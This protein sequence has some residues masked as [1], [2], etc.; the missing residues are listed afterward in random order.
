MSVVST[1]TTADAGCSDCQKRSGKNKSYTRKRLQFTHPNVI[2]G[3][4]VR[5]VTN[6][7]ADVSGTCLATVNISI[8][9]APSGCPGLT[10]PKHIPGHAD[11]TGL[12]FE[13]LA[14]QMPS[15]I[16]RF[17][18]LR[19]TAPEQAT[20]LFSPHSPPTPLNQAPMHLKAP[21]L[22]GKKLG[23]CQLGF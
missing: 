14:T 12:L 17:C 23:L 7:I 3:R 11:H 8:C 21:A 4:C 15:A 2:P 1:S 19:I 16:I 22:G 5:N 9:W 18:T 20:S 6:T 10:V 13:I